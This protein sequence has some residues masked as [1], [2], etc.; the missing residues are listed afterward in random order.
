MAIVQPW[1]SVA[2]SCMQDLSKWTENAFNCCFSKPSWA[3]IYLFHHGLCR[4]GSRAELQ[5]HLRT[6][7]W[8][9]EKLGRLCW[10]LYNCLAHR[11]CRAVML[12]YSSF[13]GNV[14]EQSVISKITYPVW[15]SVLDRAAFGIKVSIALLCISCP[16][17]LKFMLKAQLNKVVKLTWKL[18][19]AQDFLNIFVCFP[20]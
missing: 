5:L 10:S 3:G 7:P 8:Q 9:E 12:E 20:P 6:I 11:C 14:A 4:P 18:A 16:C 17:V 1:S 13:G 2:D 15:S 19:G